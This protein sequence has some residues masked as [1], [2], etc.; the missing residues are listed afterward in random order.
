MKN[1][2]NKITEVRRLL[3][4]ADQ[5]EEDHAHVGMSRTPTAFRSWMQSSAEVHPRLLHQK[6]LTAN[7][8]Y[9]PNGHELRLMRET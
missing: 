4:H 7:G 8:A 5:I 2:P 9:G 1:I 6:Y 3:A